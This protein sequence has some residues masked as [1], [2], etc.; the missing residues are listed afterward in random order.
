MPDHPEI[1]RSQAEQYEALVSHEDYQEHILPAIQAILP[2]K[3]LNIVEMGAG[4]GRLTCQFAPL[5]RFIH[6][7][8]ISA[9]MLRVA[10]AK[11]H[12]SGLENWH[13]AVC[14]HRH[15]PIKD[16]SADLVIS[17]WSLC[18]LFVDNP[19]TWQE[20]LNQAL[21]E[22]HRILRAGGTLILLETLGTGFEQPEPPAEL[23]PY[24]AFLKAHGFQQTW[25]RTD[26][27]FENFVQAQNLA[28][29]FFGDNM[30]EKIQT[31]AR[32]VILP[33]CTGIWWRDAQP[34]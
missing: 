21:I 16:K 18:Y 19:N 3:G 30:P 13:A 29:F 11:L 12:P 23:L 31:S 2:L 9:H 25:I 32:G 14:D 10:I 34:K 17:G 28:R 33:E 15:L 5:A 27:R 20:E 7:L 24:Y 8:D 6:A 26:Y 4:T 22:I 1:Y